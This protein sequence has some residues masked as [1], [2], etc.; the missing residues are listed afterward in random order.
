MSDHAPRRRGLILAG[1]GLKVAFEAGVLQVWLD[2]LEDERL[3]T[4]DLA[5][6]ASGGV[7]NLAMW[8]HGMSGTEIADAWRR[9]NPLSWFALNPRPWQAFSSLDRFADKV[10]HGV[11]GIDRDWRRVREL[12]RDANFNVYNFTDQQLE[13]RRPHEMNDQWLLACVSLPFWFPP[14]KIDGKLYIDSVYSTDANLVSAM[15]GGADEL[16]VVWTMNSDGAWGAGPVNQYFATIEAAANGRL[17]ELKRRIDAS[18]E[19][20]ATERAGEFGRPIELKI[21]QAE[22]PMNYIFS[23]NP[24]TLHEAVEL[25]VQRA[26]AWCDE[27]GFAR[28]QPPVPAP[29]PTRLVFRETMAGPLT[30]EA[31]GAPASSEQLTARLEIEADDVGRFL[32]D[33]H[34]EA[35]ISGTIESD[36]FGG[37]VPVD[38][39][40][41]NLFTYGDNPWERTMRYRIEFRDPAGHPLLLEGEKYVPGGPGFQPWR[42]TTTMHTRIRAQGED[43]DA[44]ALATGALRIT[45]L[46]F[47]RQLTTFRAQGR[48]PLGDAG[49]VL[50]FFVFFV[51]VCLRVY[52]G[53]RP[54]PARPRAPRSDDSQT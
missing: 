54:L 24:D 33:P 5:D 42:D 44:P 39:G 11:W 51:G 16:W 32:T 49:L 37:N 22:V 19:L 2:E 45:P 15:E 48:G 23:F 27:Q 50:R 47:L 7:F 53:G 40:T 41:F 30:F 4:F 13:Q 10:L 46:A 38:Q 43:G 25:G 29:A 8:C 9:T 31:D 6:G 35:S 52:L 36:A 14:Q 18:N 20:V 26:R 28:R 34:H 12:D 3:R 17:N 21:L 1:G